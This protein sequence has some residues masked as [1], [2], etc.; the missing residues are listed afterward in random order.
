[1]AGVSNAQ[2]GF[3]LIKKGTGNLILN[4]TNTGNN[5]GSV[6]PQTGLQGISIEGGNVLAGATGALG[7]G[8]STAGPTIGVVT[9]GASGGGNVSILNTGAFTQANTINITSGVTGSVTLGGNHATGTSAY[10]GNIT[11]GSNVILNAATG[12]RVDFNVSGT[13]LISGGG[14]V[15]IAGGGMV[16]MAGVN[17]YTGTTTIE[18]GTLRATGNSSLGNAT[19]DI[20]LGTATSIASNYSATLR[21]NGP[22]NLNRNVIVGASNAATT[23]S[24]SID[25]DNGVT[26]VGLAGNVTLNQNLLVSGATNGGFTL[27]GNITP[28]TADART[29]TFQGTVGSITASGVISD[30][31]GSVSVVKNGAN[32][33]VISGNSTYSGAT[34]VNAGTLLVTGSLNNSAITVNGGTVGGTGTIGGA[35][36]IDATFNPGGTST[37]GSFQAGSSLTLGASS[38]TNIDLGG[39]AFSLNG[40][41]EYDRAKLNS[42]T[43]T[44]NLGGA[45]GVNLVNS[46][47]LG[48]DQ[49]FGIFQ[50]EDGATLTGTFAG[51]LEGGLVGNYGGRDLFI[52]YQGNFGD[53]GAVDIT[54]GNDIVLYTIPEP[55]A[56]ILGGLGSLLLLRRRK[57]R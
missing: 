46:F 8:G 37:T 42:S 39:T 20:A 34:I 15:T 27:S 14:N 17:T 5:T 32:T 53:T 28:G 52:T 31:A 29:V 22:T 43:A 50:L 26:A 6:S 7:G 1:L 35:L 33:L 16:A 36:A 3:V 19:S 21:L 18:N 11:L 41:E 40:T 55:T 57:Q 51:L 54:G 45:L 56:A 49:A 23:G 2:G 10:T 13:N 30:G 47:A 48:S 38:S 24:Y 9:L 12:G 4:A 44:V 25:T